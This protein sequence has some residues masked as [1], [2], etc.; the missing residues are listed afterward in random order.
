[1]EKLI[2]FELRD[3]VRF[4]DGTPFNAGVVKANFDA[5]LSNANRHT[6][7]ESIRLMVEV[8]KNWQEKCPRFE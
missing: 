7:L 5:L 6:W 8:E 2:H 3:D 4:S 1:M